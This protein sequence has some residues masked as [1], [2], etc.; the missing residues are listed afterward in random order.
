MRWADTPH[1]HYNDVR[2]ADEESSYFGFYL[3]ADKFSVDSYLSPPEEPANALPGDCGPCI[4]A[5]EP[6]FEP[7][8]EPDGLWSEESPYFD[9][10]VRIATSLVVDNLLAGHITQ[11]QGL[12]EI[13]PMAMHHPQKIYG[14][15]VT[16][17]Q[18]QAW[19]APVPP[20]SGESAEGLIRKRNIVLLL[21]FA[22]ACWYWGS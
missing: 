8:S 2:D 14:G 22:L 15:P 9:G 4:L 20:L 10:T 5:H 7:S 12:A 19:G 6:D 13:W 11:S 17:A 3:V 16:R 1:R 21:L 18:L